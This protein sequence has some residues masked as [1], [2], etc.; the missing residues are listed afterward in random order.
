MLGAGAFRLGFRGGISPKM[1]MIKVHLLLPKVSG[2]ETLPLFTFSD[3]WR[4]REYTVKDLVKLT[5]IRTGSSRAGAGRVPVTVRVTV[6]LDERAAGNALLASLGEYRESEKFTDMTLTGKE[7]VSVKVHAPVMASAVPPILAKLTRGWGDGPA[8]FNIGDLD[9]G[10]LRLFVDFCYSR[11]VGGF[12]RASSKDLKQI[13]KISGE[14]V[15]TDMFAACAATLSHRCS[16]PSTSII[17]IRSY[18]KHAKKHG[19]ANLAD[20]CA[21]AIFERKGDLHTKE[22]MGLCQMMPEL[23]AMVIDQTSHKGGDAPPPKKKAR[24]VTP[25]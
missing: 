13:L 16:A 10:Q 20:A 3:N 12:E 7:G 6:S 9:A 17:K 18:Y 4:E 5:M 14:L 25:P 22:L 24:I 15:A 1:C 19:A 23:L 11:D 8:E 21:L 2:E